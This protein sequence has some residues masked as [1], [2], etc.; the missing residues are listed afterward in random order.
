MSASNEKSGSQQEPDKHAAF[1]TWAKERGVG[2][3]TTAAIKTGERMLF[4]PEK[5]MH[6][7]NFSVIKSLGM[8]RASPQAK[9]AASIM[10]TSG[11]SDINV[12]RATWPT[13]ADIESSM[14]IWWP[15]GLV[16]GLPPAVL[17]PLE[18]QK[19][20]YAK[21]WASAKHVDFDE[22]DF[23]YHWCIVNSRS[24]H[25]KPAQKARPG[26]MV[27]CPFIDYTN[28]GPTGSGCTVTQEADG[29][30]AVAERD[31]GESLIP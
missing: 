4:I 31:Y 17:A 5:A 11:V 24:F 26:S 29:Y 16:S 30:R 1:T 2:L 18:R 28:H 3:V 23:K 6:K 7:T 8:D 10:S 15:S 19:A 27:L 22:R 13:I 14:P 20:D 9:L 25:W 12:W 21:D